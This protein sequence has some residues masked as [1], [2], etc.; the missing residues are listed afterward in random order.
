MCSRTHAKASF[1]RSPEAYHNVI[2][3]RRGWNPPSHVL[4]AR[5]VSRIHRRRSRKAEKAAYW[6][7]TTTTYAVPGA[8]CSR[9]FLK[10]CCDLDMYPNPSTYC[11]RGE[12]RGDP[13]SDPSYATDWLLGFPPTRAPT[14]IY[15]NNIH[16]LSWPKVPSARDLKYG[17]ERFLA[18]LGVD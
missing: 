16:V 18:S 3:Q 10:V 6:P 4:T 13:L 8:S 7:A 12:R 14:I 15:R 2:P 5:E 9:R 1:R 11:S 17:L